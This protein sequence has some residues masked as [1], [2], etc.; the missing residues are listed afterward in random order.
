MLMSEKN[1]CSLS[2]LGWPHCEG[3]CY[4]GPFC[5]TMEP[6]ISNYPKGD[7]GGDGWRWSL[8]RGRHTWKYD[9]IIGWPSPEFHIPMSWFY[10][11]INI[12]HTANA[13]STF[14]NSSK[15]V[16]WVTG[17]S[18]EIGKRE[19]KGE[20]VKEEIFLFP[21]PSPAKISPPLTP[22]EGLADTQATKNWPLGERGSWLYMF[23][24]H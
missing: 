24:P 12:N 17:V 14:N 1:R 3:Q 7:S 10:T 20:V 11:S 5:I 21:P 16:A 9:P 22:K 6:L 18:R 2:A 23:C 15:E 13:K 19:V 8:T 4:T